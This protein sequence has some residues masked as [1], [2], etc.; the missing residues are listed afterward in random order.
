MTWYSNT[1]KADTDS[2]GFRSTRA[3]LLTSQME[4]P[5]PAERGEL[6]KAHQQVS[7]RGF[8]SSLRLEAG[9][10]PAW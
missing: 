1:H 7:T 5:R 8:Q 9:R 3:K 6:A 2:C 10:C 4:R